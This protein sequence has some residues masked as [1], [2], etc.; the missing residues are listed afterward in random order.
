[1]QKTFSLLSFFLVTPCFIFIS[2][3]YLL[4]LAASTHNASLANSLFESHPSGVAYAALPNTQDFLQ[5]TVNASDGRVE[6]VRNFFL[7]YNSV[8]SNYAQEIVDAADRY[9]ISYNLLPA[10][11]MQ[12]SQG[13]KVIPDNSYNCYGYG[14]YKGH[15]TRFTSYEEGIDTVTKALAKHYVAYGLDTPEKIMQKWNPGSGS[16]TQGV[17]FFLNRL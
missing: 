11:A 8:L 13:C 14:I 3:F 4:F 12:E 17:N 2:L 7:K 6:S 5:T 10:I 9:N 16:W 1:M 15:V